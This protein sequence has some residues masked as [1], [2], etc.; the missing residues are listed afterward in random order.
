[1]KFTSFLLS[2][3]MIA[4][5]SAFIPS[6]NLPTS[7]PAHGRNT[8]LK[9]NSAFDDEIGV[10]K[11][12]GFWD[13]L[14]FCKDMDPSNEAYRRRRI[15]EYKHGRIAMLATIGYIVPY[16]LKLPGMLSTS[17]DVAFA[18][19]P[20]GIDAISKVP[21]AG[22]LQIVIFV[23]GLEILAPQKDDMEPGD[24]QPEG[25][26]KFK[27]YA[28]EDVRKAKLTKELNNGRLAMVS[29]MGLMVGDALTDKPFPFF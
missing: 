11:P 12:L 17:S 9:M 20:A 5:A 1:M 23:L 29:I 18:D 10:S 25:K 24:V 16:F 15:V 6:N 22:W 21:A 4:S 7:S 28:D 3:A 13:P 8:M 2:L 14:G 19:V 26:I 27:R